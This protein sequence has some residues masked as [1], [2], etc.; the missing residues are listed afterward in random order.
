M[1]LDTH[2]DMMRRLAGSRPI[3]SCSTEAI[4]ANAAS[5]FGAG[6]GDQLITPIAGRLAQFIERLHAAETPYTRSGG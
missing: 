4:L 6:F 3:R 2:L 5:K 1:T